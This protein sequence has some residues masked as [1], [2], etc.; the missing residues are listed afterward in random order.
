MPELDRLRVL[1][2]VADAGSLA[3]AARTLRRSPPAVTRAISALEAS[4]GVCLVERTTRALQ[5]TEAGEGYLARARQVLAALGEA[6]RFVHAAG[7]DLQG[8]IGIT[9]PCMF[10][11]LH[12]APLLQ[13]FLSLHPGV[14]IRAVLSDRTLNLIDVGLQVAVRIGELPAS[15]LR[16][17]R[18]GH[19][20]R[21]LVAAPSYLDAHGEPATPSALCTHR[22]AGFAYEVPL[23]H[24][25]FRDPETSRMREYAQ[26]RIGLVVNT[27]EVAVDWALGGHGL[28]LALSY[29]VRD[30][31]AAGRL[32]RVLAT[33]EPPPVPVHLVYAGTGNTS[34]KV[35]AFVS[36]MAGRLRA[37]PALREDKQGEHQ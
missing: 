16:C 18:V 1:V 26:P 34:A 24:W 21:V 32:R 19:V 37:E 28:A 22:A 27:Q 17:V 6:E 20:R 11:R 35:R 2:A 4:L 36:F 14:R 30:H 7:S 23:A 25:S 13:Q 10:G 5:F 31:L 3:A 29:Q 12:V 8:E 15:G 9:A 33:Y